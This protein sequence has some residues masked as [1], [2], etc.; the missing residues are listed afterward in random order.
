MSFTKYR[1]E[2]GRLTFLKILKS[3]SD[4]YSTFYW[5]AEIFFLMAKLIKNIK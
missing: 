3:E 2:D 1:I 5:L 4:Q